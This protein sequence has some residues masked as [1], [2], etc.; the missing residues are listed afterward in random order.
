MIVAGWLEISTM[1]GV[2]GT[3]QVSVHALSVN[4]TYE[5]RSVVL[6][7]KTT[8][9]E[10]T[11]ASLTITQTSKNIIVVTYNDNDITINNTSIGYANNS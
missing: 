10:V 2:A 8:A 9:D 5:D 6:N 7:F 3:T 11:R 4:D 1:D